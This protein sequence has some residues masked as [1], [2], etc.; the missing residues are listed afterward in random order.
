MIRA[1]LKAG[2]GVMPSNVDELYRGYAS[3]LRLKWR[4]V[5][6]WF[7][8]IALRKINGVISS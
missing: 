1:H 3:M 6:T 8:Y 4:G 5:D 2:E 7:D